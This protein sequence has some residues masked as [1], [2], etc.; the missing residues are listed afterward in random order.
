MTS[1]RTYQLEQT[2]NAYQLVKAELPRV[3]LAPGQVRIKVGAA[4]LNYRDMLI[5]A[6]HG[7]PVRP[8]LIPLSDGAGTVVEVG[9]GVTRWKLGDRVAPGFFASWRE[10]RFQREHLASSL[11]GGRTDGVLSEEITA[12]E[13]AVVEVPAHLT[14]A[15]AA[16]LPCAAVTAWH[17]LMARGRLA[18]GD[19]VVIQGTGGVALFALQLAVAQ[20][21]RAIVLSSS[22]DKLRRTQEMGAWQTVNYRTTPS[23]HEEVLRLTEGRGADLVLELG[24]Q[25]TYDRSIASLAAGGTIAQVGVLT[26]FVPK[27]NVL[28]LQFANAS[29]QGI[30]VGAQSHFAELNAFLSAHAIKPV[31]ASVYPFDEAAAAYEDF[32]ATERFGKIVITL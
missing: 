12:D 17:A 15:E 11:G 32:A 30:C 6:G 25:E 7:G 2:G 21:A 27:P 1:F 18:A 23:W 22:D 29:I 10:G 31:I 24:G 14:L 28:P 26:G 4:S 5:R 3:P 16:T 9:A 8:G 19:T 20:G 13:D